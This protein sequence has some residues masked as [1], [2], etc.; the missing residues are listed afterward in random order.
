MNTR[1]KFGFWMCFACGRI[2]RNIG[3]A[4]ISHLNSHVRKGDITEK[5]LEHYRKIQDLRRR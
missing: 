3:Y 1:I 5:T 2:M 4:K